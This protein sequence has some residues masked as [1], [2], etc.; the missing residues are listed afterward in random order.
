[1]SEHIFL[2]RGALCALA[3]LLLGVQTVGADHQKS[4][5]GVIVNIGVVPASRATGFAGEAEKHGTGHPSGSQHIVVSLA[6]A[7]G[8]EHIGGARV[9][10]EIKDPRGQVEKKAL[11]RGSTA[12]I[13]DYSGIFMFGW[14]GKYRIRVIVERPGA[15]KSLRADF[16]WS[17][18]I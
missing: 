14:S 2:R 4:V 13:P 8:G 5:S 1:M 16:V 11:E 6:D 7:K 15:G 12:G 18:S 17:H 10:V 9:T 3:V